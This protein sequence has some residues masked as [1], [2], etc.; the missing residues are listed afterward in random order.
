MVGEALL[1]FFSG[2]R[3]PHLAGADREIENLG[4][5]LV[6]VSFGVL[7][8]Q[9]R[10]ILFV[11]YLHHPHQVER[12]AGSRGFLSRLLPFPLLVADGVFVFFSSSA[13]AAD[14]QAG[15]HGNRVNPGGVFRAA[16]EFRPVG[17]QPKKNLLGRVVGI[18]LVA[19]Q[20]K[21]DPPHA[22]TKTLHQ[23]HERRAVRALAGSL[24]GQL[25][26]GLFDHFQIVTPKQAWHASSRIL[27]TLVQ[28][29]AGRQLPGHK[30]LG[31]IASHAPTA[32]GTVFSGYSAN[33]AG[34]EHKGILRSKAARKEPDL[35]PLIIRRMNPSSLYTR[36][37]FRFSLRAMLVVVALVGLVLGWVHGA[38]F[39]KQAA[40]RVRESNPS[41]TLLYGYEVDVDGRL[42]ESPQPPGPEW[43]RER[44]GVDYLSSVVGADMFYATDADL[45]CLRRLPNLRRLNLARSIDVTDAGLKHL[46]GLK[47]LKLLVLDDADQVTDEGLRSLGHLKSLALLQLD[48]GRRMTPQG[49][50]RLKR[51]LPNCRIEIHGLDEGDQV[52][53]RNPSIILRN[54]RWIG[55]A[56][57][58]PY[59]LITTSDQTGRRWA[60]RRCRPAGASCVSWM[61]GAELR[62]Q[63]V[64]LRT[65]PCPSPPA[66]LPGPLAKGRFVAPR[67]RPTAP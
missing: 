12:Q 45:K 63:L 37:R 64:R 62:A 21:A 42:Q 18:L 8:D 16:L 46:K 57:D 51:D 22:L 20:A 33:S 43:L 49:I 36:H 1:Q 11:Q 6:V 31:H 67:D 14:R 53:A 4:Q 39:Q 44:L 48:L 7:E 41:A 32:I 26:V 15:T 19:Q 30:N 3:E 65:F 59:E 40:A 60:G 28:L 2:S 56:L 9:H 58:P 17:K 23:R 52:L 61:Q 54:A 55:A 38:R 25:L 34:M 47:K 66:W 24:G 10:P 35:P 29:D 27:T 50:E 5:L 13:S